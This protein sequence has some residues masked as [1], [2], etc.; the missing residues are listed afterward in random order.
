MTQTTRLTAEVQQIFT[1]ML[2]G[3]DW[4]DVDTK[5]HAKQK[6][7]SMSSKIGYP[8]YILQN[9]YLES[10]YEGVSLIHQI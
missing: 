2:D 7:L 4:L 10:E 6:L 9:E 1:E 8:S 3:S 5:Q